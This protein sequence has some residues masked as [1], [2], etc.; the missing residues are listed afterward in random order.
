MSKDL[1]KH[2]PFN[3]YKVASTAYMFTF[4]ENIDI[5][6]LFNLIYISEQGVLIGAKC[7]NMSRGLIK[8][9]NCMKNTILI[10]MIGNKGRSDQ[11]KDRSDEV[12]Q[13]LDISDESDEVYQSTD[14]SEEVDQ[15][16]DES[17]GGRLPSDEVDQSQDGSE[18]STGII[19]IK[20][21]LN[22]IHIC[23]TKS[24]SS[25][26]RAAQIIL[27]HIN[28]VH[29]FLRKIKS[30]D[31]WSELIDRFLNDPEW[32]FDD[33]LVQ[34]Y[35]QNQ[36][37]NYQDLVYGTDD[38]EIF[39]RQL[40][41]YKN[42]TDIPEDHTIIAENTNMLNYNYCLL[43]N[44]DK[45]LLPSRIDIVRHIHAVTSS[46]DSPRITID[47]DNRIRQNIVLIYQK[48]EVIQK[49]IIYRNGK[50]AHSGNDPVL[51]EEAY[52]YLMN[53]L[54]SVPLKNRPVLHDYTV[55]IP[56]IRI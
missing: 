25:A 42:L 15:S 23:G 38:P 34:K 52:D 55:N 24:L 39:K 14:K 46:N 47:Y 1:F 3:H 41:L 19:S 30:I 26:R 35:V 18:E 20:I 54:S 56:K 16:Q 40:M 45:H 6:L 29:E 49:F 32:T 5:N 10:N 37:K 12:D 21:N 17:V 31:N 27:N 13:S 8:D 2:I 48:E 33:P 43:N 53:I 7:Q 28:E 22:K 50:I 4:S 9:T 51:M 44:I 11:S 36:Y